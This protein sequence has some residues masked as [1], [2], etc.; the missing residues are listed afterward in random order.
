MGVAD[1]VLNPVMLNL[2]KH[3]YRFVELVSGEAVEMLR[4]A[5]HDVLVRTFRG[6]NDWSTTP[7][8]SSDEEGN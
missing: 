2:P 7:S 8:P 6:N 5:Q 1:V 3:L 4:Q